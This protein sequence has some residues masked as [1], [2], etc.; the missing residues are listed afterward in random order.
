MHTET[1]TE[2]RVND[3]SQD[4]WTTLVV[5]VGSPFGDDRVGWRLVEMLQRR[6]RVPARLKLVSEATQLIDELDGC[7]RLIVVDACRS[8]GSLG[9]VTR[10]HWPDSRIAECHSESTHGIGVYDALGLSERL[11]WLPPAVDIF[12]IEVGG[13][14]PG[15]EIGL[16]VL[17]GVAE[18]ETLILAELCEAKNA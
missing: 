4:D 5:G 18:L 7:R 6:A 11:G 13:C 3:S 14:E 2:S 8:G 10:L 16:E 12:G 9:T 15:S 1:Q 17:R